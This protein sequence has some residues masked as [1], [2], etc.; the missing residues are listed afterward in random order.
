MNRYDRS[1]SY[2]LTLRA[3]VRSLGAAE[4]DSL[5]FTPAGKGA[6][7]VALQKAAAPAPSAAGAVAAG[8]TTTYE[9]QRAESPAGPQEAPLEQ[10]WEAGQLSVETEGSGD[11]AE[12][13][14]SEGE[15]PAK[16]RKRQRGG[17]A[18]GGGASTNWH[19][20][21]EGEQDSGVYSL[22]LPAATF[23][24]GGSRKIHIP[25]GRLFALFASGAMADAAF[26][27]AQ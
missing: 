26:G 12:R 15:P 6:A 4:G 9:R 27:S 16:W 10:Q 25:G 21:E 11:E 17:R 22:T 24:E 3:L 8:P 18:G 2:Y 1:S 19:G 13:S 20:L 5:V 7:A 23:K 14:A